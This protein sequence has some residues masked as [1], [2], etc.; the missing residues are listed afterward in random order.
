MQSLVDQFCPNIHDAPITA[1][2]YDITSGTIATADAA[3]TVAVQ[4][5]GEAAPGLVFSV[6]A[7][8]IGALTLVRGGSMVAV[9]DDSGTVAIYSTET[10][11]EW[12]KEAREGARGR[13]RAMRGLAMSPE[14]ARLAA[15]AKDGHLRVWD[16]STGERAGQW[17][18]FSGA[19]VEFGPRGTRLLSMDNKGQ[20]RIMDLMRIESLPTERLATPAQHARFTID[21]TMIVA[22]GPAGLSLLRLVD[23]RLI[24][25]F[26]I[27]GGSGILN[28]LLSPDGT[29]VGVVTQRSVHYF[30]LPDFQPLQPSLRHNAPNPTGAGLWLPQIVK[31]AGDDGMLHTGGTGTAGAVRRITGY[32]AIRLAAHSDRISV[33]Q[34]NA[35]R[36]AI[37]SSG[38]L[39]NL[40]L[41]R[42]GQIACLVPTRGPVTVIELASGDEVFN[43][44]APSEGAPEVALGGTVLAI[45]L[46]SGGLRWWNLAYGKGFAL[47]WPRT[48]ALSGSGAWM[49]VV[50]PRGAV[51][52][53]D[54]DT[55]KNLMQPPN[56]TADVPIA[57]M[58][59]IPKKPELLTVDE[60]G[61]LTHYD[62]SGSAAGGPAA[63]GRDLLDF[64]GPVDRVWG[65][66]GGKLAAVRLPEDGGS[67][68]LFVDIA[69][70]T[71]AHEATGL[72]KDAVVDPASGH[73]L[74]TARAAAFLERD[75]NGDELLVSRALPDDQ[76]VTFGHRGIIQA[77]AEA[78]HAV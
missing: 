48:V 27:Q 2:Y 37:R 58:A 65:I 4:R 26:A 21:G 18:G 22:A 23:G 55:G 32:G 36:G 5:P 3:G 39:R 24:N 62:L 75:S 25:S 8:V 70:A 1:A 34:N 31:V 35:R 57:H 41:D 50:T 56:P 49:G 30:S 29:R 60:D 33:W 14:G 68:I 10:G 52:I 15:I 51:R 67:C 38:A 40:L 11:E 78:G 42:D 77:S 45:R 19:S 44:G 9:G 61:V 46:K 16:L 59:F 63:E 53:L 13:V 71:V 69:N 74:E 72:H 7:P 6:D 28:I 54:P 76:W 17:S 12:F 47:D 43:A 66:A 73:I 64:N 20:P